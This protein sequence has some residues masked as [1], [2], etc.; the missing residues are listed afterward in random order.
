MGFIALKSAGGGV[1][2]THPPDTRYLAVPPSTA[3]PRFWGS[4]IFWCALP[5]LRRSSFLW[6]P[7]LW[8]PLLLGRPVLL[9]YPLLLGWPNSPR[10]R[11]PLNGLP[12][13]CPRTLR[14]ARIESP[15]LA[16]FHRSGY[17]SA[18]RAAG[19]YRSGYSGRRNPLDGTR[20]ATRRSSAWCRG[21]RGVV[22]VVFHYNGVSTV[23][24][25]TVARLV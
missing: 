14:L 23:R 17:S 22:I 10:F 4:I 21:G 19:L 12:R 6:R 5:H 8:R 16:G 11:P 25:A 2:L 20:D 18:R 1:V 9:G 3:C 13:F 7:I 15:H 24:S